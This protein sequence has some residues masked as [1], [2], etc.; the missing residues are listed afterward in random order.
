MIALKKKVAP[1]TTSDFRPIALLCFLS[2]ILEKIAHDQ[3]MDQY[4][5]DNNLLDPLQAGFR[6]HHRTQTALLKLTEDIRAGKDQKKV[7]LFL[8]FDFSKAFDTVSPSKLLRKLR[9]LGFSSRLSCGLN[10]IY[11][12]VLRWL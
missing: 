12:D 6:R 10:H 7:T 1:A 5:R 8:L 11:K 4:L 3:I 2:K 9:R